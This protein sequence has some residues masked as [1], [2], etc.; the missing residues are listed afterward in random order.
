MRVALVAMPWGFHRLPSPAIG[1]LA[2]FLRRETEHH[3]DCF[4]EHLRVF[5]E[6]RAVYEAVS[7]T[8]RL[9]ELIYEAHLEPRNAPLARSHYAAWCDAERG[10][11]YWQKDQGDLWPGVD[12]TAQFDQLYRATGSHVRALASRLAGHYEIVGFTTTFCQL[13]SSLVAARELKALTPDVQIVIGGAGVA[14]DVGPSILNTFPFVDAVIQGRGEERLVR[15]L[16]GYER[17]SIETTCCDGLLIRSPAIRTAICHQVSDTPRDDEGSLPVPDFGEYYALAEETALMK[18]WIPVETT[19]RP[20]VEGGTASAKSMHHLADELRVQSDRYENVK[21]SIVDDPL[22]PDQIIR[23][24]DAVESIGKSVSFSCRLR[25]DVDPGDI[26]RLWE[27]GCNSVDLG[28]AGLSRTYLRRLGRATTVLQNL[29]AMRVCYELGINNLSALITDFPGSTSGD[30]GETLDTIRRYA[31][32]FQP[33]AP[34]RF[35]LTREAKGFTDSETLRTIRGRPSEA[36]RQVLTP[37]VAQSLTIPWMDHDP[38]TPVDWRPLDGVIRQWR[39]L[40]REL[41]LLDG[42]EWFLGTRPLYYYDGKTFL[43]ISDRRNGHRD[44]IVDALS[45]AVYLTCTEIRT[46]EQL[47]G[48][49]DGACTSR[50][51]DEILDTF[52]GEELM[53]SEDDAVL[54]LAVAY[55]VELAVARLRRLKVRDSAFVSEL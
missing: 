18:W 20:Q 4:F 24:A 3:V 35:T 17:A 5:T 9:G 50:D 44:F 26:L 13:F 45:R 2:A 33:I 7:L 12:A 43:K 38:L 28:I 34:R 15:W 14:G 51:I 8:E 11:F 32:A 21:F 25:P 48:L 29:Q 6:L 52:I 22:E 49:F 46:R 55:R 36:M 10:A 23:L 40:H 53:F 37:E 41:L 39:D 19:A 47:Y 16:D 1:M 30:V 27:S 31:V 54:S 42:T